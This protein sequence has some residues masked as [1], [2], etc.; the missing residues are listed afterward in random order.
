MSSRVLRVVAVG[1]VVG[2]LVG[3]LDGGTNVWWALALLGLTSLVW[4]WLGPFAAAYRRVVAAAGALAM[5]VGAFGP[6]G[7]LVSPIATTV[8]GGWDHGGPLVLGCGV[9]TLAT[10]ASSSWW[11]VPM[12]A[13]ATL[14]GVVCAMNVYTLPGAIIDGSGTGGEATVAWGL[15]LAFGGSLGLL[16][17]AF[18]SIQRSA[19]PADATTR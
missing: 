16:L 9:L 13:A 17:A 2:G 19:P 6:W 7:R 15:L 18:P 12:R 10:V 8:I 4:T 14:A 3:G 11:R 5:I 1:L